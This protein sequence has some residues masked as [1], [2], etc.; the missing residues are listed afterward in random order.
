[1]AADTPHNHEGTQPV[2]SLID[3]LILDILND[4]GRMPA[5]AGGAKTRPSSGTLESMMV[6]LAPKLGPGTPLVER[7]LLA[8]AL[9]G[10]LA[11]ALAPPLAAAI[12]PRI[13]ALMDGGEEAGTQK[14]AAPARTGGSRKTEK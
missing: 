6:G 3:D 5:A 7:V 12:A 10:A 9:A 14:R 13:L 4:A 1:M 8:E 11:D 2:D